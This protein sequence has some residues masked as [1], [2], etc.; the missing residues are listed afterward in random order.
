MSSGASSSTAGGGSAPS[1]ASAAGS[2]PGE[3]RRERCP[4]CLEPRVNCYCAALVPQES[5]AHFVFLQHPGETRNPIGTARM[6]HLSLPGSRLFCGVDFTGE[7]AL[8]ALIEG[9]ENPGV[10]FPAEGARPLEALAEAAAPPTLIVLDGT[11]SQAKKLL[12]RNAF[13]HAL[14]AYRLDPRRP[15]RYRIRAEPAAHCVSTIEAVAAALEALDGRDHEAMLAP[16]LALVSRQA[17]FGEAP[18]RAPRRRTRTPRRLCLPDALRRAP[19]AALIVHVEANGFPRRLRDRPPGELVELRARRLR[20]GTTFTGLTL[21]LRRGPAFGELGLTAGD[22]AHAEP[23]AAL[24]ARWAGF[25]RPD[26][27]W[28]SWGAF[29][30]D[31]LKKLGF[32]VQPGVDLKHWC[33]SLL[34]RNPGT[35]DAA[36]GDLLDSDSDLDSATPPSRRRADLQLGRLERLFRRLRAEATPGE[37]HQ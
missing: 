7:A 22:E 20:D 18:D 33:S 3:W 11:W 27:V 28:L 5:R 26:D 25:V 4:R 1:G 6:A 37:P 13:L 2:A 24:R 34:G 23:L 32:A 9:A 12:K 16:F 29:P 21:P 19:D 17:G 15:S 10:L 14:P 31:L 36:A 30:G 8:R 35:L